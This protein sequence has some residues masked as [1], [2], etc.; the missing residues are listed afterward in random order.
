MIAGLYENR[1]WDRF[2][3]FRSLNSEAGRVLLKPNHT[4]RS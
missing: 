3:P 2:M 4:L 1:N